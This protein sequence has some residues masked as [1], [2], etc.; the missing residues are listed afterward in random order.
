M[1]QANFVK[2]NYFMQSQNTVLEMR[3][4]NFLFPKKHWTQRCE[5]LA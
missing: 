1:T 3:T 2:I 5:Q 4:G